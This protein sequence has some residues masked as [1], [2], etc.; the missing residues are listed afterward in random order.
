MP[1]PLY[2]RSGRVPCNKFLGKFLNLSIRPCVMRV[3]GGCLVDDDKY[4]KGLNY[5]QWALTGGVNNR[6]DLHS[7]CRSFCLVGGTRMVD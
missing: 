3:T 4:Q 1:S 6:T 2:I 7:F 5:L